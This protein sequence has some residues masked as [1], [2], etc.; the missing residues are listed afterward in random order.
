MSTDRAAIDLLRQALYR[1]ENTVG[2]EAA[3]AISTLPRHAAQAKVDIALVG[4]GQAVLLEA[5]EHDAMLAFK[6]ASADYYKTIADRV[7][8]NC[9]RGF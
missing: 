8:H 5:N 4:L 2:D 3:E 6:N 9:R 7:P 1:L